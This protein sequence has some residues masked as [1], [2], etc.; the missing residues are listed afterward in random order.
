MHSIIY[1]GHYWDIIIF[2]NIVNIIIIGIKKNSLNN[3]VRKAKNFFN[4]S[5]KQFRVRPKETL[6]GAHIISCLMFVQATECKFK[7]T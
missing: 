3:V 7:N 5:Q 4:F 6:R 2:F 1:S